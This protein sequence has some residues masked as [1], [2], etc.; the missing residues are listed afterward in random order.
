MDLSII[1]VSYN[2]KY[3]LGQAL[4]SVAKAMEGL[5]AEVVVVDNNS[6]DGSVQFIQESFPWVKLIANQE[7]LGFSKAN[8]QAMLASSAKYMLLLNPDTV[9]PEDCFKKVLEFANQH[10]DLGGLGVRMLDGNGNFLP[11]SK[12]GLPTPEVAFY[13]IFGLAKI[14][15]NSKKFGK[16]HLTY[17]SEQ[18]NHEVDILSGAFMLLRKDALDKVGLLDETYFMYGEDIDLS[19]RIQKGGYKNYY[20]SETPI[21]HYKGESTKKG[22]LNYVVVFYKAMVIFAK[23]HFSNSKAR[24]FSLIINFAVVMRAIFA[25]LARLFRKIFLPLSDVLIIYIGYYLLKEF[26]EQNVKAMDG[27]YYPDF[28][29]QI[30]VPIYVGIWMLSSYFSGGYDKPLR[31][32]RQVRGLLWGTLA[33]LVI[34]ALLDNNYRASRALLILGAV[35]AIIGTSINHLLHI[36]YGKQQGNKNAENLRLVVA[37]NQQETNRVLTL[38]QHAGVRTTFLGFVSDDGND[39]ESEFYL[40]KSSELEN[41]ISGMAAD[42][43]VFCGT[44]FSNAE[45]IQY[46]ANWKTKKPYFKIVQPNSNYII[47]SNSVDFPGD[48]YTPDYNLAINLQGSKRSKRIVDL[49]FAAFGLLTFPILAWFF[50]KPILAFSGLWDVLWN[51]KTFVAYQFP[52]NRLPKLKAGLLSVNTNLPEPAAKRADRLYAKEYQA[53]KDLKIILKNWRL[54]S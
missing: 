10:P 34:Y 45:I 41:I 12:R 48:T 6:A 44:D 2:V 51:K 28:Y 14:F 33:L 53:I 40:G 1:I 7:N 11:E 20:F 3:F 29:M 9:V 19:Y 37:G 4:Q 16:Y 32:Y 31:L 42:E 13:K 47:G 30:I 5:A 21:I 39:Q 25:I 27:I 49:T 24:T 23:Q 22:S 8:N 26:W 43:L 38:L 17:L 35:W 46:L 18:E 50:K 54:I 52:D 15:N 36:W